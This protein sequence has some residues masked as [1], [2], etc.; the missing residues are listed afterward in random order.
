MIT[1][2]S[3]NH[4][5]KLIRDTIEAE[6]WACNLNS[7]DV[8]QIT[9]MSELFFVEGDFNGDISSWNTCKVRDMGNMFRGTLF[10]GD[11]SEWNVESVEDMSSMFSHSIFNRDISKWNVANVRT[12]DSLFYHSQFDSS[13][14]SWDVSKCEKFKRIFKESA[15][16]G[17]VSK[18]N[19][20]ASAELSGFF[21]ATRATNFKNPTLYHWILALDQPRIMDC[22]PDAWQDHLNAYATIAL[23][24]GSTLVESAS[25]VQSEWLKRSRI[26]NS[27]IELSLDSS[28]ALDLS[29]H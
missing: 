29:F 8:S 18:W 13:L 25:M 15:F 14:A 12:M 4:L 23:G 10:N 21:E 28:A 11:I 19:I 22:W 5:K 1:A 7:I 17:D 9:D 2:T 3:K 27:G 20:S 6:G 26:L 16:K 24:L